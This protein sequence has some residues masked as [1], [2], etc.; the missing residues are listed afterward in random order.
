MNKF[1]IIMSHT[2]MSRVKSKSFVIS[3]VITLLFIVGLAN[4]QSII[5]IFADESDDRIAVMD[6]SNE[7]L[8]PFSRQ[9]EASGESVEMVSFDGTEEE[10]KDMVQEGEFDAL[11]TLTL[12]DEEMPEA[13]Y[14]ANS[15][16][17]NGN[18][19]M[20]EMQLQ[21]L[22]VAMATQQSGID[23]ETLAEIQAPAAFQT[24]ALDEGSRTEEELSQA[25]G[26]VYIMLFLLYMAVIVYGQ[27]IATDVATEKSSRVMEILEIGRAHV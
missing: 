11:M 15:I 22:K 24:V 9:V 4:F 3:T 16:S 25:R 5:E 14:Y 18:Q 8:E 12:N 19:T 17:G 6:E 13:T 26:I 7:L 21:Q 1:W 20:L 10:A 27:M 2:Y 23:A